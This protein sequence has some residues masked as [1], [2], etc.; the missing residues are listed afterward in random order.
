MRGSCFFAVLSIIA[1]GALYGAA[2]GL[3]EQQRFLGTW[4]AHFQG[5]VICTLKL[6]AGEALAG[7]LY[8][9]SL[10]FNG[11]GDL[12][13]VGSPHRSDEA[14]PIKNIRVDGQTLSFDI[15]AGSDAMHLALVLTTGDEAELRFLQAPLKIKPIHFER[16]S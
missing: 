15:G 10:Q 11:D 2:P 9:C 6:D 1:A 14:C 12:T 16:Q 5:S 3:P 13:G 4:Q 7:A 8:G